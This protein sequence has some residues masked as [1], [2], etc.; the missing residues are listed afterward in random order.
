MW[1]M[2]T[3]SVNREMLCIKLQVWNARREGWKGNTLA[4]LQEQRLKEEKGIE[5]LLG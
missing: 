3:A 1:G 4:N 2:K 5:R